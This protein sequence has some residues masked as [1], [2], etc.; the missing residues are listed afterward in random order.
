[1]GYSARLYSSLAAAA[2]VH[3]AIALALFALVRARTSV[4]G[5]AARTEPTFEISEEPR[6]AVA[7]APVESSAGSSRT[8]APPEARSRHAHP[9]EPSSPLVAVL[10]GQPA[11]SEWSADRYVQAATTAP[12]VD[13]GVGSYWKNVAAS[14]PEQPMARDDR[15]AE[16]RATDR[17]LRDPLD[18]LDEERGL[19][20]AGPLVSAAHEA[21]SSPSAP[22]EGSAT[23]EVESNAE[24]R[25]TK[26]TLVSPGPDR[27]G[28]SA[29]GRALEE[30]LAAKSLR[31]PSGARGVRARVQIAAKRTLPA[32]EKRTYAPGAVR[33]DIAG[34]SEGA[35]EC[36][37]EGMARKC[38]K[39]SP[40][41]ATGTWGDLSNVG[42]IRTRVVHVQIL[43]ERVF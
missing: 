16:Q 25:V 23:Y 3:G 7:L 13:V 2:G 42:Q 30:A 12:A 18:A 41:G 31:V 22:D 1:M 6:P 33:D 21:A 10:A 37:G 8:G 40:F 5:S 17:I 4:A 32:G 20:R 28:W 43:G 24:G 26:V 27:D 36:V 39:G 15:S 11:D 19:G 34:T 9:V 29:V 14:A 35:K 38:T